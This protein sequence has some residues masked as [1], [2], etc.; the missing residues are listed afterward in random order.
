MMRMSLVW[1]EAVIKNPNTGRH[2]T[3]KAPVDTGVTLTVV[4]HKVADELGLPVIGRSL[5]QTAKG[6]VELEARFGFIEIMGGETPAR[7]LV[8][9]EVNTVLIGITV[10]EQLGLE[11]EVTGK[12]KKTKL[13]LL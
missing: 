2:A 9:D 1:V 11:V 13:L 3:A 10:L 8:S 5:V 7:I 6:V 12:L 4:S